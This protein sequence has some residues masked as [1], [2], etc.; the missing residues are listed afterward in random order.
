VDT[1]SLVIP[2]YRINKYKH[3]L[4]ISAIRKEL[5][6]LEHRLDALPLQGERY[7][8]C[9][10]S[11]E[12]A[13]NQRRQILAW[14]QRV[15][16]PRF[17]K[18]STAVLSVGCG[19]GD[20]D[21]AILAAGA[22]HSAKISYVGVEPDTAQCERFAAQMGA[23]KNDNVQITAHN[24]GFEDFQSQQSYDLVLMVHSLY[25]MPDPA[26]AI[27]KALSLVAE[28]GQLV[29]LLAA[30][31]Q[32]NELSSSF[33]Q[34]EAGRI[35]WFSQDLSAYLDKQGASFTCEQ[36]EARLDVT[37]CFD[38]DSVTGSEIADF[39]AQVSTSEL[40]DRLQGMIGEYLDAT[41]HRGE[42]GR[43][44]PHNVDAF[45]IPAQAIN[46]AAGLASSG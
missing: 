7:A 38:A 23:D 35:A 34:I 25:Y 6:Q 10:D 26:W 12:G 13:S 5:G 29:V 44:L 36:I 42:A 39:L 3:I 28:G 41:S 30:N 33:W 1:G 27:D 8:S 24:M 2:G 21:K 43:W 20:L 16:I 31:D 46:W 9:L 4:N 14:I 17:S 22:E 32:L 19:A 15:L 11:Y 45:S 37:S 40:P 18:Q